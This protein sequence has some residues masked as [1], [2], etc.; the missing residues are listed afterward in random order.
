[1][2][3]EFRYKKS[4]LKLLIA[5]ATAAPFILAGIT[6]IKSE[7]F[8]SYPNLKMIVG[9]VSIIFWVGMSIWALYHHFK[10]PFGL[11]INQTGIKSYTNGNEGAM[12]KWEYLYEAKKI[13]KQE[14]FGLKLKEEYKSQIIASNNSFLKKTKSNRKIYSCDFIIDPSY[15]N[16]KSQELANI[17]NDMKSL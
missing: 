4:N 3:E 10:Y 6:L 9:V 1:M 2:K 17:I 13:E 7:P 14:I 11:I 5:M 12:I 16:M 8:V 15:I